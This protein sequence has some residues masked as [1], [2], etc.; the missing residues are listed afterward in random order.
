MILTIWVLGVAVAVVVVEEVSRAI[1]LSPLQSLPIKEASQPL[2][3][4]LV[5][6]PSPCSTLPL[7]EAEPWPPLHLASL[8][9]QTLLLLPQGP[10]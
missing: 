4:I 7:V 8:T 9:S 3:A 1:D 2:P 5:G 10:T 6:N